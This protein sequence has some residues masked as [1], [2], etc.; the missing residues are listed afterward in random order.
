M[1]TLNSVNKIKNWLNALCLLGLVVV[2]VNCGG[3][4]EPMHDEKTGYTFYGD[5]FDPS[6]TM[7]V[8]QLVS[9]MKKRD[10]V[11][12]VVKATVESVCKTKGCWMNVANQKLEGTEFF[13]KFKD[14]GFFVPKD[15][16]NQEVIIKGIAYKS[17][18]PVD[19]LRHYAED[20]GLSKEEIDA[21]TEPKEEYQFMASGV[22]MNPS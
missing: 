3:N 12:A 10:T 20:K 14:Y 17:V 13:V 19:E 2:L 9:A 16:E 8:N 11:A 1:M 21:I 6:G 18:T 7:N 4:P 15:I 22:A 5:A